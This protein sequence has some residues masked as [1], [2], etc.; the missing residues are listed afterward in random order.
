MHIPLM[1]Y[2]CQMTVVS[3]TDPNLFAK[4]KE[5]IDRVRKNLGIHGT[6]VAVIYKGK[7][8]YAQGFG[9]RN[10]SD[11]FTPETFAPIASITKGFTAAAIGEL[12]ARKKV[13]WDTPGLPSLDLEWHQRS[14][15]RMELIK[16]LKYVDPQAPLRTEFIYNNVMVAVAG[17]V[18]AS[19]SGQQ[20]EDLVV[21]MVLR[22]L[23]MSESGFSNEAMATKP[24]HAL[25]YTCKNFEA[26]HKGQAHRIAFDTSYIRYA[27][28][29]AMFSNVLE[30]ARW[31]KA[32]M[33]HGELDG[34][35]VLDKASIKQ[36]RRAHNLLG[37]A[38][39][40]S[41]F[42]IATYGLG[43][44]I[45]HYKGH[46]TAYHGGSTFGY[47]SSV[48]LFPDDDLAIINLSNNDVN[49]LPRWLPYYIADD[50]LHLPKTCDWLFDKAVSSTKEFYKDR[51]FDDP[52]ELDE[53]LPP[54]IMGKPA[55]KPLVDFEGTYIHP[56]AGKISLWVAKRGHGGEQSEHEPEEALAF[57]LRNYKGFM[58]HYHFDSFCL[59]VADENT[60]SFALLITFVT[61]D[62]GLV[63]HCR[64][65][66]DEEK[67]IL[68]FN[69]VQGDNSAKEE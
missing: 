55:T 17:E 24:N 42:S 62:N 19:I 23:S 21:Q 69:K 46:L 61:G 64:V 8:V 41:E 58:D 26:A 20:Y 53:D 5:D 39:Q 28:A 56:V 6:S 60:F 12:V 65:A 67:P 10:D 57:H 3:T 1:S 32:M 66:G 54:Q 40:S 50:V 27:P 25:P 11:P 34:S 37:G 15:S 30:L 2:A 18:A 29:V 68:V 4:W 33:H 35:Q 36:I 16:K 49:Q 44:V 7:I 31:A 43:W 45:E 63:A 22:P 9:K 51:G 59:R 47:R 52:A 48:T 14:E 13:K 38:P